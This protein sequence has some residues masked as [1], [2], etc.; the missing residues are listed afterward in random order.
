MRTAGAAAGG[1]LAA[2]GCDPLESDEDA[3]RRRPA[4]DPYR[5]VTP[6][7]DDEGPPP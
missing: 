1:E 6:R 3:A 2:V 4:D 5:V 7:R